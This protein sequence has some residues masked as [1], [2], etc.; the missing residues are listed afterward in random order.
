MDLLFYCLHYCLL[1][2]HGFF[3]VQA[4]VMVQPGPQTII[5]AWRV[6]YTTFAA[7]HTAE[8][9]IGGIRYLIDP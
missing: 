1:L 3:H 4:I 9:I 6:D 5:V 2:H 7:I 8:F